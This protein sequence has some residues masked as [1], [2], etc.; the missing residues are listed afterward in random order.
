MHLI[1]G[2][3]E[4]HPNAF[5][6]QAFRTMIWQK[7]FGGQGTPETGNDVI[8]RML[9]R[10]ILYN[11]SADQFRQRLTAYVL[12]ESFLL[13]PLCAMAPQIG[14]NDNPISIPSILR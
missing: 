6:S 8:D 10:G 7:F 9:E 12:L 5:Y 14:S 13:Q 2:S 1:D 4:W 3:A 11:H